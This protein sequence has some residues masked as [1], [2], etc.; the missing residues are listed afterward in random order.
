M[1]CYKAKGEYA[2]YQQKKSLVQPGTPRLDEPTKREWERQMYEWRT[3]MRA[4]NSVS[5]S[6][7]KD[8]D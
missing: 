8:A 6:T 7:Q 1:A 3:A 5:R 2:V 4:L